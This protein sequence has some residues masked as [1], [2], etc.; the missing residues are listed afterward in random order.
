VDLTAVRHNWDHLNKQQVGAYGEYFLKMELTGRG[1]QVYTPEV[2]DRGVDFVARYKK[3]PFLEVQ[4]K[5]IRKLGYVF[6]KKKHFELGPNRYLAVVFLFKGKEPSIYMI[7]STE[8][9]NG[10]KLLASNDYEGKKSEPEFG[11]NI[12]EAKLPNLAVFE[13]SNAI[14]KIIRGST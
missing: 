10:N 14:E 11:I 1:F 6:V 5:S 3:G 4:V 12:T 2:D 13:F 7:P 9:I 8:W